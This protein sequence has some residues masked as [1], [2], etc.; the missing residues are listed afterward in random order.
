MFLSDEG[1]TFETLDFTFHIGS[2]PLFSHQFRFL[3]N[4][5]DLILLLVVQSC[6]KNTKLKTYMCI[7]KFSLELSSG[8][9]YQKPLASHKIY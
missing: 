8:I 3:L 2:T 7:L 4:I 9:S 6:L 1:P 5:Q